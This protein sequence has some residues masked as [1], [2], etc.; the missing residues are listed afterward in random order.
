[1]KRMKKTLIGITTAMVL[2]G[3]MIY[4]AAFAGEAPQ[5]AASQE[6]EAAVTT[7]TTQDGVLSI[8][9]PQDDEGW[10][11]IDGTNFWFAVGNGTDMITAEHLAAGDPLPAAEL[12]ND[13]FAE[14]YQ[15]FYST[16]DEV[17]I[18]TGKIA[19]KDEAQ[20]VKEAVGSFKVLKYGEVQKKNE[21]PQQQANAGQNISK[22]DELIADGQI[23][24]GN[25]MYNMVDFATGAYVILSELNQGGWA[26]EETGEIFF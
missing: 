1:M 17:F 4:T 26:N 9:L 25:K 24:T 11:V 12:A 14:I 8:E 23:F 7:F 19:N 13:Q 18:V 16:K 10:K 15:M 2:A 20:T 3:T 5:Q 21:Q 6:A 22:E